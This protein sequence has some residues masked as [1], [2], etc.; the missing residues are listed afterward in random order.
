M[1]KDHNRRTR[2]TPGSQAH[3]PTIDKDFLEHLRTVHFTLLAS[4]LG[5]LVVVFSLAR[6]E[7]EVA[8]QQILDILE[9]TANWDSGFLEK[10]AADQLKVQV[11]DICN[12][13]EPL[14]NPPRA[15]IPF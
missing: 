10:A 5:L 15:L 3:P 4:C 9:V 14:K 1:T 8:H 11:N 13:L 7:I 12:P 2:V 6:S